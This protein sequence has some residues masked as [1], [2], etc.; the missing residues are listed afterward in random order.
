[1][2]TRVLIE[3]HTLRLI[4]CRVNPC[5]YKIPVSFDTRVF[6]EELP[7]SYKQ[8][9]PCTECTVKHMMSMSNNLLFTTKMEEELKSITSYLA[10]NQTQVKK[11]LKLHTAIFIICHIT[12]NEHK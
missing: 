7:N 11:N 5:R 12:V 8:A 6:V 1:M 2:E 3:Q 10:L 4:F 9:I